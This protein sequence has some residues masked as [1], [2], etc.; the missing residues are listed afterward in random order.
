[1]DLCVIGATGCQSYSSLKAFQGKSV[2]KAKLASA[3]NLSAVCREV[4]F[5]IHFYRCE[6]HL[7]IGSA[8]EKCP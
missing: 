8:A 3:L 6:G 4:V 2:R 1:M 5:E 7:C